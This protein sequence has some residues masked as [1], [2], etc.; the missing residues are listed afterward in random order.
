MGQ[1][2]PFMLAIFFMQPVTGDLR[3]L[4]LIRK[5][6]VGTR[7]IIITLLVSNVIC[8]LLVL[9]V[10]GIG[11]ILSKVYDIHELDGNIFHIHGSA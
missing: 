10:N 3:Y 2:S 7:G 8:I 5:A 9:I 4:Q 6:A 11:C 1:D